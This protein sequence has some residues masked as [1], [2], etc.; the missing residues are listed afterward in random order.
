[1]P[2]SFDVLILCKIHVLLVLFFEHSNFVCKGCI[3]QFVH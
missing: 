1:M 3:V 2:H